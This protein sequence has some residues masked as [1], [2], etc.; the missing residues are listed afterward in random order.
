[1]RLR[2]GEARTCFNVSEL[3]TEVGLTFDVLAKSVDWRC[4]EV[5]IKCE[6]TTPA[7]SG[8]LIGTVIAMNHGGRAVD[9]TRH[10]HV[11][12]HISCPAPCLCE[13]CSEREQIGSRVAG[14]AVQLQRPVALHLGADT[15]RKLAFV[16]ANLIGVVI[17][18]LDEIR[19]QSKRAPP[20]ADFVRAH[21]VSVL[22]NRRV[23]LAAAQFPWSWIVKVSREEKWDVGRS[24]FTI[25]L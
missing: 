24:S 16:T 23:A 6:E 5:L 9:Q 10:H 20:M 18:L 8:G 3:L 11:S 13:A 7:P 4:D 19:N 17:D 15:G 21:L 22:A 2:R 14:P 25:E 1:M 12:A